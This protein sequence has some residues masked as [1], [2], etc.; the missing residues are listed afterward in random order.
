MQINLMRKV[1]YYFG[2]PV[3]FMLS[4]ANKLI[5]IFHKRKKSVSYKKVLFIKLWGMGSIILSFP[6]V[7]EFKK[8]YPGCR[9][10]FMTF[11]E[12]KTTCELLDLVDNQDIL[13]VDSSSMFSV[14]L[15]SLKNIIILRKEKLDVIVDMEFF[16]RATAIVSF[17]ISSVYR[18]GFCNPHTEGLYRGNFLTH[19]VVYNC[20]KHTS[21]AFFAMVEVL[22][23]KMNGVNMSLPKIKNDR[24]TEKEFFCKL[25]RANKNIKEDNELIIFNI[26]SANLTTLRR[27]P[28]ENFVALAD[29][30]IDYDKRKILVFIGGKEDREY[31]NICIE[32]IKNKAKVINLTGETRIKELLALY[33]SSKIFITNDS[34]PAHLASL[35]NINT[36]VFFGPETPILYKPLSD[37]VHVFF[38]NFY[39]SPCIT[40]YN[41]KYSF[42]KDN[43]CLK[44]I[45]V[46]EVFDKIKEY[47]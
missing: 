5:V 33:Y 4:V 15:S 8:Q 44:K 17:L 28:K 35:S 40:V 34:G 10:Y 24:E 23:V 1:D 36:F 20:Y 47:F 41:G 37:K 39:C 12:N 26:N 18:V 45:S 25:K 3:C 6:A 38:K 9:I 42:C 31:V 22:G 21:K 32:N 29:K 16:S 27:W 7:R 46:G 11:K 30:I 19:P 13:T 43:Q 2:M 14:I